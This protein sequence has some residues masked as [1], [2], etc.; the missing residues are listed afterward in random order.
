MTVN[1]DDDDNTP[2][3]QSL[4]HLYILPIRVRIDGQSIFREGTG[5]R[6]SHWSC[7]LCSVSAYSAGIEAL[8]P[9]Y[10]YNTPSSLLPLPSLPFLFL[11]LIYHRAIE[12]GFLVNNIYLSEI[13]VEFPWLSKKTSSECQHYTLDIHRPHN[14]LFAEITFQQ[15]R[16]IIIYIPRCLFQI[17]TSCKNIH[18]CVLAN[19]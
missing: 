15:Q 12:S 1:D 5:D 19:Y 18:F 6:P 8:L 7:L 3:S 10:I 17:I 2:G 9:V 11:L 16:R 4:I 14:M 13:A